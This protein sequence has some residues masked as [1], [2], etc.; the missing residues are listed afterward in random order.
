[1]ILWSAAQDASRNATPPPRWPMS[2]DVPVVLQGKVLSCGG[3]SGRPGMQLRAIIFG[4][5]DPFRGRPVATP[6]GGAIERARDEAIP[7][8]IPHYVRRGARRACPCSQ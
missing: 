4:P 8:V 5:W 3:G 6:P 1:Q 2:N 7:S